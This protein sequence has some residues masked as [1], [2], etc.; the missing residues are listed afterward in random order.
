MAANRV[1]E[2]ALGGRQSGARGALSRR[3]LLA[4]TAS[5]VVGGAACGAAGIAFGYRFRAELRALKLRVLARPLSVPAGMAA[6]RAD[7]EEI[8]ARHARQTAE[9]VGGLKRRYEEPMFGKVAVWDLVQQ[10]AFVID[11]TDMRLF[12]GSQLVHF[13]QVVAAMEVNGVDDPDMLLLGVIHDLGK[14]LLLRGQ[15]PEN[16]VCGTARIGAGEEGAGLANVV[17]QFGHGEFIYSRIHDHVPPHVAWV[18]RYHNINPG[19]AR[20]FMS[21]QEREWADRYLV[22]FQRYDGGFVSP[23]YLPKIEMERYR[24]LVERY[25]PRPIVV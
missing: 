4:A 15:A 21:E 22:P 3:A 16:V 14:V 6:F 13:Q 1:R 5:A 18:A 19:D 12:C 11:P 23:Y 10:L 8:F 2:D 24:E 25:F 9:T 7:A 20:L 17:F